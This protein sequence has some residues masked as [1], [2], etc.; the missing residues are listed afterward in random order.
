MKCSFCNEEMI[1][2]SIQ[3][4]TLLTS[5]TKVDEMVVFLPEGEEKKLLPR[6]TVHLKINSK[7]ANY[8]PK[9]GKALVIFEERG[10]TF[11]Q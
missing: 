3:T 7:E 8:C 6:N 4:G 1:K 10:N 11:W 5:I 2:G 9:C